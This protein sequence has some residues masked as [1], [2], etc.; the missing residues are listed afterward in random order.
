MLPYYFRTTGRSGFTMAVTIFA[1]AVYCIGL[2]YM[3][4]KLLDKNVLWVWHA[5]FVDWVFRIIVYGAAFRKPPKA[6]AD[7]RPG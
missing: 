1:M 6:A 3:F 5:M 7:D 2:A 4:V